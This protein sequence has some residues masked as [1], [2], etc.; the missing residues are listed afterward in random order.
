MAPGFSSP[1]SVRTLRSADRRTGTA[2][3]TFTY[4]SATPAL[5]GEENVSRIVDS[6]GPG[7]A[8]NFQT[9]SLVLEPSWI[10]CEYSSPSVALP[11]AGVRSAAM[12]KR[13]LRSS[14]S[15]WTASVRNVIAWFSQVVSRVTLTGSDWLGSMRWTRGA[16]TSG[17]T[18]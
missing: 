5:T 8:S 14:F 3:A 13:S 12:T 4:G 18:G 16:S 11:L 7:W 1:L 10:S 2:G 17:L 15:F 9:A 6:R